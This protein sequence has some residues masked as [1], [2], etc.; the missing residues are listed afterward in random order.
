LNCDSLSLAQW[1][2]HFRGNTPGLKWE[3]DLVLE[4]VIPPHNLFFPPIRIHDDFIVD[5]ILSYPF[6]LWPL[7][8]LQDTA[9]RSPGSFLESR[10]GS[11]LA[12]VEDQGHKSL[13][14]RA[15]GSEN[16]PG[17]LALDNF[18]AER[19][20]VE[21]TYIEFL[22]EPPARKGFLKLE[23]F[24]ELVAMLPTHLRP[25]VTFLYYCGTRIGEALSI[26][27]DQVDFD[28]RLIRLEEDQTK[29]EEARVLP[30]PSV[31][32]AMLADLADAPKTGRV[33][34][35]TNLR[36]EWV[37]ACAAVGLGT[38]TEVEGKPYDPVYSGLTLHDLRRSAV[39]NLVRA[40]VPETVAM[41]ISGHKTRSV[42]DRYNI[43]SEDDIAEAMRK[44]ETAGLQHGRSGRGVRGG[45]RTKVL[46]GEVVRK[47]RV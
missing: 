20:V 38:L 36:K 19:S 22:K 33:F 42:F 47:G 15:D 32:V 41:K 4:V 7:H 34:D 30:L 43:T 21:I 10:P 8:C 2:N 44:L 45:S 17:L 18:F 37:K 3:P 24:E 46:V 35:G 31:L 14:E 12:S 27:W 11:V 40:G 26:T 29:N 16:I 25:L 28:R 13:R 1:R 6:F 9:I 23:Q 5:A 39:R